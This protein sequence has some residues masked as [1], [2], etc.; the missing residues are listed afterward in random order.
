VAAPAAAWIEE[1]Y[2]G[3]KIMRR[4]KVGIVQ[5]TSIPSLGF[6]GL[7]NGFRGLPGVELAA[8]V[9]SNTENLAERMAYGPK[10]HYRSCLEMMDREKPDIVILCS[11]H[12]CEHLEQIKAAAERGIHLYCEKPMTADL[13]EADQVV[14][15]A[16]KHRIKI[17][18]A[19]PARY[20]LAFRT[21]KTMVAAGEIGAPLRIYGRGKCDHRGGG[22]DLVVLG[23]HIL[24]LQNYFFGAPEYVMADVT[25]GGKPIVR[26]DRIRTAEPL[27]PLAGNEVFAYFRFPGDVCG[28]FESR[29]DLFQRQD[30]IVHMGITVAG[31]KGALSLR[32]ND[33][34]PEIESKL[35]ISR[36]PAPPEDFTRYEEVQLTET[37]NIPG[38]EPL[39]YSV[40]G[41]L[42]GI[43]RKALFME[44][45]R[46]AAWDLMQAIEQERLPESNQY[47]ARLTHEM[48]HGIYA[49]HLSGRRVAFPLADRRH[50]L[51][52]QNLLK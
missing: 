51:T 28:T 19:H 52:A 14:A 27:G 30:N 45:N 25:T 1:R 11:R 34:V 15:L 40:G 3:N 13:E 38:A 32:F 9:D 5:D 37:R 36:F 8:H 33:N 17:C 6:H 46:Y 50:P 41:K 49:S 10:K 16:E 39:D 29:H 2:I 42:Y 22:E 18:M 23:T 48:I 12:P 31:T 26:T 24:D 44:S 47:N 20:A 35:R 4:W 7:H 43:P 21:M